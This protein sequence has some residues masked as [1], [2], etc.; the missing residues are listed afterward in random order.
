MLL[1]L[2][3]QN[4]SILR[5]REILLKIKNYF[6][7]KFQLKDIF[8]RLKL[9]KIMRMKMLDSIK[10]NKKIMNRKK[11]EINKAFSS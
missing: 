6:Q 2:N 3:S 4:T 7:L 1:I 10:R 11:I 9:I 8:K 5:K